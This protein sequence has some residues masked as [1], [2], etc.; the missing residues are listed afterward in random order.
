MSEVCTSSQISQLNLRGHGDRPVRHYWRTGRNPI[1]FGAP[2]EHFSVAA[3]ADVAGIAYSALD[4]IL[5]KPLNFLE[6][7]NG[8]SG[9][10]R[11]F[12]PQDAVAVLI[13][14]ALRRNGF[15]WRAIRPIV[16]SFCSIHESTLLDAAIDKQD[17]VLIVKP[18][19]KAFLMSAYD[20]IR[21]DSL[22]Q[23]A[24]VIDLAPFLT[25]VYGICF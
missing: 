1:L 12:D 3:V 4:F 11:T 5:R 2:M 17:T 7:G 10:E 15:S 20:D 18:D 22:C 21:I 16:R 8:R 23:P 14:T 25:A 19:G 9:K 13:A 6:T 24:C